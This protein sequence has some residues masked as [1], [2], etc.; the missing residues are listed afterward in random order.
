MIREHEIYGVKPELFSM[1]FVAGLI[2]GEGTFYWTRDSKNSNRNIPS[3]A[4]RMHI[5]DFD[6]LINVKYSLGIRDKVHEYTHNNRHYALLIVRSFES[7]RKIIESIYPRLTG[8]KKSQFHIWFKKF[9]DE[10]KEVNN[11]A[12]YSIFKNKFP[13]LYM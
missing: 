1:D 10:T 7:L 6:L 3:F 2:V 8:Y 12:I 5:R 13:E 11:R 9:G 4:L